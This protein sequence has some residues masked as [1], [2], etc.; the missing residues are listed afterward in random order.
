M[1]D[2]YGKDGETIAGISAGKG[3]YPLPN[4]S[5]VNENWQVWV[6]RYS[7]LYINPS[8]IT[9][10]T[11]EK[12]LMDDTVSSAIELIRASVLDRLGEYT[13]EDDNIEQFVKDVLEDMDTDIKFAISEILS[14]VWAGFSVTEI[15]WRKV[16]K[17]IGIAGLQTLHPRSVTFEID[18]DFGSS[19]KNNLRKILQWQYRTYR[20][21]LPQDKCIV[22]SHRKRFGNWYGESLLKSAY[23]PWFI[24]KEMLKA[25]AVAMERYG[26]PF[27]IGKVPVG[28]AQMDVG[29]GTTMTAL[30]YMTMALQ[31]LTST[32][33]IA[34]DSNSEVS[35]QGVSTP[36]GG[37][38]DRFMAYL[39]KMIFRGIGLPSL[40]ADHGTGGGSYALGQTHFDMF[41]MLLECILN[42]IAALLVDQLITPL[43]LYNF[44]PQ[45]S[46]GKWRVQAFQV[47]DMQSKANAFFVLGNAGYMNPKHPADWMFVRKTFGLSDESLDAYQSRVHQFDV[48]QAQNDI[49]IS[50]IIDPHGISVAAAK[51]YAITSAKSAATVEPYPGIVDVSES[52]IGKPP[53]GS[54]AKPPQSLV[55]KPESA[56]AA[57]AAAAGKTGSGKSKAPAGQ[58]GASSTS[59]PNAQESASKKPVKNKTGG[60]Q[61]AKIPKPVNPLPTAPGAINGVNGIAGKALSPASGDSAKNP[62]DW[63]L[64]ESDYGSHAEPVHVFSKHQ[65]ELQGKS[66]R[67]ASQREWNDEYARRVVMETSF[68]KKTQ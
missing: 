29:N 7:D 44:G 40:I 32:S 26:T 58:T 2:S 47:D 42:D 33:V 36:V 17:Y 8:H 4:L 24:K 63:N 9:L 31:Q 35:I 55:S 66:V 68:P 20:V 51:E 37:D 60:F 16:G 5:I 1:A 67:A 13:H 22:Y 14:A 59:A 30:E 49:A 48:E 3:K 15:V 61:G 23:A 38:F 18:T 43:I 57:G 65:S 6:S 62:R 12:M 39:N 19:T 46:Y 21:E 34:M 52:I 25:W 56:G 11:Y 64:E 27:L 54:G 41:V 45:N 53:G 28:N 10:D 50:S